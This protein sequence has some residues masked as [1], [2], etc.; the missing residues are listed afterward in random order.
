M[1]TKV[2]VERLKG[3]EVE[4]EKVRKQLAKMEDYKAQLA[5][6]GKK[7]EELQAKSL[8]TSQELA[9]V[10]GKLFW[11]EHTRKYLMTTEISQIVAKC[12]ASYEFGKLVGRLT[13]GI[14]AMG[15]TDLVRQLQPKYFPSVKLEDVLGFHAQA[16]A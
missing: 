5:K 2:E 16:K 11:S 6:K 4:L 7:M 1:E 15:K 12:R 13:L 3:Q 8:M 14:Q 10:T 9:T